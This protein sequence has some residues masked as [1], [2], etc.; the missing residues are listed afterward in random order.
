M[1][2]LN[3]VNSILS[4]VCGVP[5]RKVKRWHLLVSNLGLDSL[6]RIELIIKIK[7]RFGVEIDESY[8]NSATK[9]ED[10]RTVIDNRISKDS[11]KFK[12]WS[13]VRTPALLTV[14]AFLQRLALPI[15]RLRVRVHSKNSQSAETVF[16]NGLNTIFVSNHSSHFDTL[17]FLASL[18]PKA[19][20]KIV[21]AAAEDYMFRSRLVAFFTSLFVNVYPFSRR[22]GYASF[23]R[24]RQI[25]KEGWSILFYPEGTRS[26]DGKIQMFKPGIGLFVNK[27]NIPIIPVRIKGTFDVLPKGMKLPKKGAVTV[28]FGRVMN[29]G[30]H[31]TPLAITR[32]IEEA[33]RFL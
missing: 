12:V 22:R 14:R 7:E 32:K 15:I 23:V 2:S 25:V 5:L 19:R 16:Q 29:F 1:N 26:R 24:T 20:S 4:K 6:A 17:A 8:I 13:W 21:V 9:V 30:K 27:L 3:S 11:G 28:T 10:V 18:S 31:E 33:V